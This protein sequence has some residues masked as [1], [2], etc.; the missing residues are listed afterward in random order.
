MSHFTVASSEAAVSKLFEGI[1]D[2]FSVDESDSV[3]FG[4]FTAGYDVG[5]H[6]E[7]GTVDLQN[8]GNILIKELDI[9]WD[10]LRVFA[11]IDIP[12]LCIGGFC[13]IPSPW[14]CILRA[15]RICVFD[16]N[17]DLGIDLDLSGLLTSEISIAAKPK[18][19][20]FIDPAR[21]AGMSWLD[22][23]DA[24]VANKWQLFIDP[25]WV[26]IDVF[27]WAD[28]VGDLLDDAINTAVD[29][30]LWFLPGWAKS[31][32]HAILGPVVDLVRAILDIGDDIDEWLSNLLGVSLGLF[33]LII[34]LVADYFAGKTPLLSIEDPFP[35]MPYKNGLIPVKLPIEQLGITINDKE[36]VLAA[37]LGASL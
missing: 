26:D 13:I 17:P 29:D 8:N 6:L 22:A 4:P 2:G 18:L 21:P 33:D 14:G 36:M 24:N 7:G 27:D 28:I 23:E 1:R 31:L 20:Y 3:N 16:D 12:E 35:I 5:F 25:D 32:I 9:K 30:L 37:T 10:K 11:G 15:P 19:S 34:T